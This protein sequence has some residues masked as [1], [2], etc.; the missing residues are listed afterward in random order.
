MLTIKIKLKIIF[1][2]HLYKNKCK[3]LISFLLR[4]AKTQRRHLGRAARL[5]QIM[6]FVDENAPCFEMI[7]FKI[8]KD[9]VFYF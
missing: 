5:E 7:L 3:T 6:K 9:F 2:E 8:K 1:I 4:I